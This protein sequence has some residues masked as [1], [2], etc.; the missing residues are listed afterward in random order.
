MLRWFLAFRI[1]FISILTAMK[2]ISWTALTVKIQQLCIKY[3]TKELVNN[4]RWRFYRG[5]I[6]SALCRRRISDTHY[7]SSC[8]FLTIVWKDK[9]PD[10]VTKMQTC[11]VSQ[12]ILQK[13]DDRKSRSLR[14]TQL[15]LWTSN[16]RAIKARQRWLGSRFRYSD[17][18]GSTHHFKDTI[19]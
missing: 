15:R 7:F 16:A 1:T 19:R 18:E 14:S 12:M 6:W 3:E 17:T 8:I 10:F 2:L 11:K 13:C 9:K 4:C 5:I